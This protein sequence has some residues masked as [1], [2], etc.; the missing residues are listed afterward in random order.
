MSLRDYFLTILNLSTEEEQ[1]ALTTWKFWRLSFKKRYQCRYLTNRLSKGDP[2]L[3]SKGKGSWRFRGI[4]K[5]AKQLSELRL[6]KL[7]LGHSFRHVA[8]QLTRTSLWSCPNSTYMSVGTAKLHYRLLASPKLWLAL[9][10]SDCFKKL[11]EKWNRLCRLEP[12]NAVLQAH[13]PA[14]KKVSGI[15]YNN[16]C[17]A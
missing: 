5:V 7:M 17:M 6:T 13:Q 2:F 1:T 15:L 4:P 14:F 10:F 3:P 16:Y 8:W 9:L 12:W 11:K